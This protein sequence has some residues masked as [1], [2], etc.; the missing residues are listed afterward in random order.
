LA[1]GYQII[2]ENGRVARICR[3]LAIVLPFSLAGTGAYGR[4]WFG[5]V[6]RG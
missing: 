3:A 5:Q 6:W 4:R 1:F 2:P